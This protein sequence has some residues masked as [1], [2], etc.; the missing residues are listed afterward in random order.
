MLLTFRAEKMLSRCRKEG[1]GD[2]LTPDVVK[3]IHLLD[4]KKGTTQNWRA[5]V[6][7]EP[8]VWIPA[9]EDIIEAVKYL[10]EDSGVYVAEADCEI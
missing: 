10:G 9:D 5:V 7:D 1:M 6:H 3:C 4:G 8:L 2:M